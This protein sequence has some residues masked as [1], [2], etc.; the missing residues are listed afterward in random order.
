ML[1]FLGFLDIDFREIVLYNGLRAEYELRIRVTHRIC[2]LGQEDVE[3]EKYEDR[4]VFL[5]V[6]AGIL[7]GTMIGSS[8]QKNMDDFLLR[9]AL[10]SFVDAKREAYRL[11]HSVCAARMMLEEDEKRSQ[12]DFREMYQLSKKYNHLKWSFKTLFEDYHLEMKRVDELEKAVRH[13]QLI[14]SHCTVPGFMPIPAKSFTRICP[15]FQRL[16]VPDR[17]FRPQPPPQISTEDS[18]LP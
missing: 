9:G 12:H 11:G 1:I 18:F 2:L 3:M 15:R 6:L 14:F 7:I 8:V 17:S 16:D 10:N 13:Y 4:A 5:M